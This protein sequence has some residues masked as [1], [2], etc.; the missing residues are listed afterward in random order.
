LAQQEQTMS[1]KPKKRAALPR[2]LGPF[3]GL[4]LLCAVLAVVSPVF[5]RVNNLINILVQVSV[6][7][8]L[9]AGVANVI[10]TG[11]ID[12]SVGAI[13][14]IAGVLS[15]GALK[16]TG[17]IIIAIIVA[18]GVG[19]LVGLLNGILVSYGRI[20]SFVVTLGMMSVARG[21]AF[22]YTQGSPI[23]GF[24]S[25]F[26]LFGSGYVFN[27]IPV[28]VILS[29]A[30]YLV[31]GY[32]LSQTPF[33]RAIYSVGSNEKAAVLS[34]INTLFYKTMA[35][36]TSGL[37]SGLAAI[38]FIGRINSAHPTAG[39]GYELDA[40]AA[41][42]IG[43]ISLSGGE[44]SIVGTFIGA[45]IMGVLRNGLNLLNIDPF[46]QGVVIGSVIIIAV[47]VDRFS[48]KDSGEELVK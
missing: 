33:G 41:A 8:V 47:L 36:V 31:M 30:V 3:I 9:A 29:V 43:G 5:L 37:F 24:P 19:A 26:R 14:G 48:R 1:D 6:I 42:V 23:S 7:S 27:W 39:Q 4:I 25:G 21:L 28:S 10:L 35:F 34:G 13:L 40:I 44:G 22:V 11:G 17:S 18:L 20:P 32:V 38:M 15:A 46:W 12:L 45:L 16:A 2:A